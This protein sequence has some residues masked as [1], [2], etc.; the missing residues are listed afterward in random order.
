ITFLGYPEKSFTGD[1]QP[2][3]MDFNLPISIL[4][5]S[6]FLIP[7]LYRKEFISMYS[8]LEENH[9][10]WAVLFCEASSL[11]MQT[12]RVG[13]ILF[14]LS[15][16]I[17][18]LT[19]WNFVATVIVLASAT[20][21]Y[22]AL[23]GY[24][25]VL[26]TDILQS[27]FMV[28]S[29]F[30][31]LFLLWKENGPAMTTSLSHYAE[32]I[33]FGSF[34]F[35]LSKRTFFG[36]VLFGIVD[37]VTLFGTD[38]SMAQ[39]VKSAGSIKKARKA[40]LIGLSLAFLILL[41]FSTIGA[42]LHVDSQTRPELWAQLGNTHP[43]FFYIK[44]LPGYLRDFLVLGLFSAAISSI[45]SS[46]NSNAVLVANR[47]SAL[48]RT[49]TLSPVFVYRVASLFIGILATWVCFIFA[50]QEQILEI[51]WKVLA[52]LGMGLLSLFALTWL[53]IKL[54]LNT[55]LFLLFAACVVI[56]CSQTER[57]PIDPLFAGMIGTL[58]I[59]VGGVV[60]SKFNHQK[61]L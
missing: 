6:F 22:S 58:L 31:I 61:T 44:G 2:L 49:Q 48:S 7:F 43:L 15:H 35:S 18:T 52:Y 32:Q 24:N 37:T 25:A 16:L 36:L 59:V 17:G 30:T 1:W 12:I 23:G 41:C 38:Q 51:W 19:S 5:A 40:M 47:L 45:D 10:S 39:R 50:G 56:F 34:D 60:Q 9:G 20:T 3:T 13:V 27:A 26:K 21:L 28:F 57:L 53:K 8:L 14:L 29:A 54:P 46:I 55:F 4:I 42:F 33:H 11:L